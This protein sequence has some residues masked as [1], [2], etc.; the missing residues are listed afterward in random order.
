LVGGELVAG[1]GKPVGFVWSAPK[2]SF[3]AFLTQEE[4]EAE[5]G[6]QSAVLCSCFPSSCLSPDSLQIATFN[7]PKN[8]V[9][10]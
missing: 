7:P 9:T 10:Q 4:A 1:S 3:L 5:A 6:D 8:L 2:S